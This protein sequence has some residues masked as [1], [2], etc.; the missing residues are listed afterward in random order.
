MKLTPT[1]LDVW[2]GLVDTALHALLPM[3]EE[4][5]NGTLPRY[6][7]EYAVDVADALIEARRK[8]EGKQGQ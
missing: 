5:I 7:A 3:I 4:P 8:R 6:A 1:E 2:D